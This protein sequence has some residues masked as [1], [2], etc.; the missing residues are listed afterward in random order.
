VF[1]SAPQG[2]VDKPDV[3]LGGIYNP[4]PPETVTIDAICRK[5]GYGPLVYKSRSSEP[6]QPGGQGSNRVKCPRH[7]GLIGGGTATASDVNLTVS[8]PFDGR[9]PDHR[10]DDGWRARGRN[11]SSSNPMDLHVFA[12]CLKTPGKLTYRKATDKLAAGA[13]RNLRAS[14][15]RHTAIT[16]GGMALARN[17]AARFI[18]S[19]RPQDS[20][21]DSNSTPDDRW[22]AVAVNNGDSKAR[23]TTYA[24]CLR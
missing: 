22:S 14:C 23:A 18:H 24:I 20:G 5:A 11:N 3:W 2:L 16:D 1:D 10:P 19:L 15:P 21:R 6:V 9:D 12:I 8:A 17:P 13:A 4:G 7:S